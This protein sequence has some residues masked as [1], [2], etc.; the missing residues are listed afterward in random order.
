MSSSSVIEVESSR[1][2]FVDDPYTI[3]FELGKD[4]FEGVIIWLGEGNGQH[5]FPVR[6]RRDVP[7]T[8]MHVYS[9]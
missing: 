1:A 8:L 6:Q 9:D 2:S 7:G 3:A 5:N 4:L